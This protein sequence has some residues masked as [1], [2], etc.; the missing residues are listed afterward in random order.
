MKKINKILLTAIILN[1][2]LGCVANRTPYNS[3]YGYV[4]K[5][6][7]GKSNNVSYGSDF[8]RGYGLNYGIHSSRIGY[9]A[10][11]YGVG[12]GIMDYGSPGEGPVGY[13]DYDNKRWGSSVNYSWESRED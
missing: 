3:D 1:G 2:L 13:G 11:D 5:I 4:G 6:Y 10:D 8:G 7:P 12:Y 9:G